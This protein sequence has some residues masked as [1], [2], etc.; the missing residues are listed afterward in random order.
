MIGGGAGVDR[1][2]TA[3]GADAPGALETDGDRGAGAVAEGGALAAGRGMGAVRGGAATADGGAEFRLRV[4]ALPTDGAGWA[5][6]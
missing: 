4:R 2:V 6:V 3:A 1:G 5:G